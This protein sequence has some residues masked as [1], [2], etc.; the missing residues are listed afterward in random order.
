MW[1]SV[2]WSCSKNAALAFPNPN[3]RPQCPALEQPQIE[4][5]VA[6]AAVCATVGFLVLPQ[7]LGST[8]FQNAL[9]ST[10][11]LQGVLGVPLDPK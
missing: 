4:S 11:E 3:R 6:V 9:G 10:S 1:G 5:E 2:C 7:P 8:D